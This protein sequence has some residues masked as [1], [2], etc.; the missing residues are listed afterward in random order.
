MRQGHQS[1]VFNSIMTDP[2]NEI[3]RI[4]DKHDHKHHALMSRILGLQGYFSRWATKAM[5]SQL[6]EFRPEVVI[7]RNLHAN[8]VHFPLLLNWLARHD[9]TTVIVLHDFWFMTGHCCYYTQDK[10]DKWQSECNQCPILHKYNRSL[11]FD[12]S[13]KIFR[14]KK[15]LFQAIPRLAVVGVSDWVTNEARRSPIFANACKITRI[16]NW[17]DLETFKPQ[18]GDTLRQELNLK[19]SDFVVLGVAQHWTVEK[20][21]NIFRNLAMARPEIKFVLVGGYDSSADL[22]DNMMMIGAVNTP[23]ELARYYSM[24]NVFLNPSIQ[25]TF[26]KVS[27]E[28]LACGTP[29]I[30]NN[31]TACPEITG[32]DCGVIVQD[33]NLVQILEAVDKIRYY[34]KAHFQ[35]SCLERAKRLFNPTTNIH[36][37]FKL[38][39]SL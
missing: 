36:Q 31:A 17:V 21:L 39:H 10:C 2:E 25:E 27:A 6:L 3:Y 32:D 34:G 13:R 11:F 19:D 28:A 20:G 29:V 16:Y 12:R 9:V 4:G 35:K 30:T 23:K 5:L 8:Y 33:N 26:G 37:Y 38:F 24:A 15:R 7:L 18:Q 1:V 14:D 22:P